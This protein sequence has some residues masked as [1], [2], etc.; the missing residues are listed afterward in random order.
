[1]ALVWYDIQYYVFVSVEP[2]C[3]VSQWLF[4]WGLSIKISL[5]AF[6]FTLDTPLHKC[7]HPI[8]CGWKLTKPCTHFLLFFAHICVLF[9]RA[10]LLSG[11][12]GWLWDG[13]CCSVSLFPCHPLPLVYSL[14]FVLHQQLPLAVLSLNNPESQDEDALCRNK[15]IIEWM[16]LMNVMNI[17]VKHL[18]LHICWQK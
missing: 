17:F 2:F 10:S 7:S 4:I 12:D 5:F 13:A 15:R 8:S 3:T 6:S 18:L 16:E 11:K 1:M 9:W 14:N